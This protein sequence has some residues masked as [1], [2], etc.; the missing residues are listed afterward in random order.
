MTL[1]STSLFIIIIIIIVLLGAPSFVTFTFGALFVSKSG[2]SGTCQPTNSTHGSATRALCVATCLPPP[3]ITG[4]GWE[5]AKSMPF[6]A[7]SFSAVT[8]ANGSVLTTSGC[9]SSGGPGNCPSDVPASSAIWDPATGNWTAGPK[10]VNLTNSMTFDVTLLGNG[11]VMACCAGGGFSMSRI[12]AEGHGILDLTTGNWSFVESARPRVAG[13]SPLTASGSPRLAT[14]LNGSVVSAGGVV[15]T[16]SCSGGGC[17]YG[18]RGVAEAAIWSPETGNWTSIASMHHP[19]SY[20][21]MTTMTNGSLIVAGAAGVELY[22]PVT[23]AWYEVP[24]HMLLTV[25]GRALIALPYGAVLVMGGDPGQTTS[26]S[27]ELWNPLTGNFTAYHDMAAGR[28]N[29]ATTLLKNGSVLILGGDHWVPAGGGAITI[30][31]MSYVEML[32]PVPVPLRS[33]KAVPGADC[34]AG[35]PRSAWCCTASFASILT[36]PSNRFSRVS[37]LAP[38]TRCDVLSASACQCQ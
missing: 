6:A 29:A 16:K 25:R 23:N 19:R 9:S 24:Q 3:N 34:T 33:C 11:S 38:P 36:H 20:F 27:T 12:K 26:K 5:Y 14:L 30:R 32:H 28:S 2:A 15:G 31:S 17:S 21:D 4:W 8:L 18:S 10:L 37:Q 1:C 35:A 13:S 22:N 7:A